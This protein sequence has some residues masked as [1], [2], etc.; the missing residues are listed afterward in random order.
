M[1]RK[2]KGFRKKTPIDRLPG[3]SPMTQCRKE[4]GIKPVHE[5]PSEVEMCKLMLKLGNLCM[6][7][8]EKLKA[9]LR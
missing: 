4:L 9:P 3:R 6:K 5:S 8:L 2:K 1:L 7:V